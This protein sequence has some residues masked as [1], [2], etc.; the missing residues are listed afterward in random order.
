MKG[1]LERSLAELS[2]RFACMFSKDGSLVS[3]DWPSYAEPSHSSAIS[4]A[5]VVECSGCRGG[6]R[7]RSDDRQ[8]AFK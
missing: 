7:R 1:R 4:G 2:H 8:K 6:L 3:E 5:D